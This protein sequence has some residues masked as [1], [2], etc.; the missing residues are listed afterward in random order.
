MPDVVEGAEG[1]GEHYVAFLDVLGFKALVTRADKRRT[2]LK[3]V[4]ASLAGFRDVLGR[5]G[6]SSI[7][8][9]QFSDS[10]I[11]SAPRSEVGMTYLFEACVQIS[12]QLL[13][14]GV[15]V[16]G[17]IVMGN[18]LH[19]DEVAFGPG[20]VAASEGD[21][22]GSPPRI[23][24]SRQVI[25]DGVESR[26]L[27]DKW[28]A[29]IVQDDYDGQMMLNIVLFASTARKGLTAVFDRSSGRAIARTISANCDEQHQKAPDV[30]AKWRWF[31]R[32]WNEAVDENGYLPR[33]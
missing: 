3:T 11:V 14:E 12:A 32:Y 13:K 25:E 30:V 9:S 10:V 2:E 8:Y 22:P 33:A 21:A 29:V 15:L 19:T 17:S 7:Q 4:L 1:Y 5:Y 31:R 20:I 23:L 16:R 6:A 27:V 24:V 26:L 28:P 18:V